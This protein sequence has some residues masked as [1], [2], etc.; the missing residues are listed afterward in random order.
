VLP[1]NY[2]LIEAEYLPVIIKLI[3][4]FFSMSGIAGSFVIYYM[5]RDFSV[6]NFNLIF[7]KVYSF[8]SKK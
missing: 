6:L 7:F 1:Q 2:N 8:L 3:P 5:L 4:F